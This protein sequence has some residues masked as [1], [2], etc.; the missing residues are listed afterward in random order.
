MPKVKRS[1]KPD[2][3]SEQPLSKRKKKTTTDL[4]SKETVRNSKPSMA[5]VNLIKTVK[6]K[7]TAAKNEKYAAF[8]TKYMRNQF[9]FL[10]LRYPERRAINKEIFASHKMLSHLEMYDMFYLLWEEPIREYQCFVLDYFDQYIKHINQ[11]KWNDQNF[12]VLKHLITHKSWWDTVDELAYKGVGRLVA[13]DKMKY[14]KLMDEWIEDDNMWL[15]RTAILHQLMYKDDTDTDRLFRYCLKCA[16]EKE[17]F[18][19]KSIGWA[20]RN[21]FRTDP[22]IIKDFVKKNEDKLAPLSKKEALKHA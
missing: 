9:E 13:S 15:R 3:I 5:V 8:V 10:G 17:F 16:H 14:N 7:Y 12:T 4:I 19:Q 6:I 11:P 20:L 1:K 18:I 22:K 2:T 21:H